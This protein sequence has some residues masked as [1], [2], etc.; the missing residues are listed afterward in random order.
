LGRRATET[1]DVLPQ[2]IAITLVTMA[3]AGYKELRQGYD[4]RHDNER[5]LHGS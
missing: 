5:I 1:A 4:S 3:G 2:I